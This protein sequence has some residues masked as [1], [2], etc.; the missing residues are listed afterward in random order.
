MF[1]RRYARQARRPLHCLLFLLALA[2]LYEAGALW[3]A[4]GSG[5]GR[6]LL[7]PRM[8]RELL[9]WLGLAGYWVPGL[10]LV[11]ALLVWH[12]MRRDHWRARAV[13][14]ALMVGESLLL[15]VPL[16]VLSALLPQERP[17]DTGGLGAHLLLA[18]GAGV[19]EELVFRLLLISGL[20]WL[21]IELAGLR[22]GTA[23][24]VAAGLA[25]VLFSLCHFE[26]LGWQP[27]RWGPFWFQLAAGV[28]LSI[29]F[30]GRGLGVSGGCH[31]AYNALLVCLRGAAGA[32]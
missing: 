2:L 6:E 15:T 17:L 19:Y 11:V 30:L 20:A 5:P 1:W 10:V 14:L 24:W 16:L 8:I 3:V 7:A 29:I 4:R 32:G 13:V 22:R 27:F 26:P 9:S 25:A 23:W 21:C 18:V 28:Y 31:A 12:R